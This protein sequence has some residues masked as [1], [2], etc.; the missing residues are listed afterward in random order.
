MEKNR[1]KQQSKHVFIYLLI[2][3]SRTL[4]SST[5][6]RYLTMLLISNNKIR[7]IIVIF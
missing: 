7:G 3:S 6:T 2:V 1:T 5:Q 4:H